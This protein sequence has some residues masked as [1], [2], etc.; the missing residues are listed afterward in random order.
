VTSEPAVRYTGAMVALDTLA[1]VRHLESAG[2][3]RAQAEAHAEAV[4]SFAGDTLAT[5]R[6][7]LEVEAR[8]RAEIRELDSRLS[9]RIDLQDAGLSGRM[10]QLQARMEQAEARFNARM[11]QLEG[12][13]TIKLGGMLVA[14]VGLVAVLVKL[15]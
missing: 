14:A 11:E 5:K 1:Y 4:A 9:G 13:M 15:F 12:R 7:L 3:P 8:L 6:D 2:V 10:D